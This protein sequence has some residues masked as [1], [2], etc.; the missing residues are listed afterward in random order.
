MISFKHIKL[1]LLLGLAPLAASASISVGTPKAAA[2]VNSNGAAVY[3]LS[4]EIPDG[5]GFHPQIGL[6]YN[7]QS[8]GYGNAGY[9][10]NITGISVITSGGK[11]Q[12]HDNQVKGSTFLANSSFSLDGKRL[13]LES[14]TEG[15]SGAK[16]TIEGDPY[17]SVTIH[18]SFSTSGVGTWFEVIGQDG[19]TYKY[20]NEANSKLEF[21]NPD[22]AN[23]VYCAAW[24]ITEAIDKYGNVIKYKYSYSKDDL[25]I[26]PTCITYGENQIKPRGIKC[27]IDFT[28]DKIPEA[29]RTDFYLL[30]KKGTISK[31]LSTITTSINGN[32]YRKYT[33]G[34]KDDIDKSSKKYTRLTSIV[35]YDEWGNQYNPVT[36]DWNAL[37]A[38]S[39][40]RRV[41][42]VIPESFSSTLYDEKNRSFFAVD[43][44]GDGISDIL[45]QSYMA[46]KAGAQSDNR[47]YVYDSQMDK[48]GNVTFNSSAT[49]YYSLGDISS[50]GAYEVQH[51]G[52]TV[53]DIDG[54]GFNDIVAQYYENSGD[55]KYF[56][57][58][59]VAFG[60][61]IEDKGIIHP[62]TY[63]CH[64][65][66]KDP[67]SQ[68]S[69]NM[70]ING[71]GR[72]EMVFI[73]YKDVI[74]RIRYVYPTQ[75]YHCGVLCVN[76][77][78]KKDDTPHDFYINLDRDPRR[79]YTGD[80]NSDGLQDLLI[81]FEDGHKIYFNNGFSNS[82]SGVFTESNSIYNKDSDLEHYQ[83]VEQGDFNGDGYPDFVCCARAETKLKLFINNR[84][85][86]FEEI[87]TVD[88]P[89]SYKLNEVF[90]IKIVDF[91]NDGKS[92]IVHVGSFI[93]TYVYWYKSTGKNF[94]KYKSYISEGGINDGNWYFTGD[95]NGDGIAELA[96]YGILLNATPNNFIKNKI[97][98]YNTSSQK[99][100][101]GKVS[102]ITD[103][104][105]VKTAFTYSFATN[106]SVYS[107]AVQNEKEYKGTV[108]NYTLP[109]SVVSKKT[110][111]AGTVTKNTTTYSYGNLKIHTSG[112]GMLGFELFTKNDKTL[113]TVEN[114]FVSKWDTEYW[115]PLQTENTVTIGQKQSKTVSD[116]SITAKGKK[117][118]FAYASKETVT[119]FDDNI[120]ET[121]TYYDTNRGVISG[122]K[123][124]N[125]G[126]RTMFKYTSYTYSKKY[127]GTYLPVRMETNQSHSDDNDIHCIVNTYEY[128]DKGNVTKIVNNAESDLKLTEYYQYDEYGHKISEYI[129]GEGV[130]GGKVGKNNIVK[131]YEYDTS[132]RFVID[133]QTV[134]ASTHYTYEYNIYGDLL[135]KTDCTVSTN[136]LVT[137]YTPNGWNEIA[138]IKYPD[139]N[140]VTYSKTWGSDY[141]TGYYVVW[142][143]SSNSPWK[144]TVYDPFGREVLTASVGLKGVDISKETTYNSK[145][146]VGNV[147]NKE[148][149]LILSET[150]TYDARGRK[151]KE[152]SS[153]GA[154]T[155]Y[156]YGKRT[157][158]VT[159]AG[160]STTT[161]YDAWGNTIR[162]TD[163]LGTTVTYTYNSNGQPKCIKTDGSEVTFKYDDAGHRI[164]MNDPDAGITTYSYGADGTLLSQTDARKVT[165]SYSYDKLGR[166][167]QKTYKD[168]S[169]SKSI[170]V[171]EY[172]T[173][174]YG[175]NRIV[176]QTFDGYE[177][178]FTYDK[179]GRVLS[180]T[181]DVNHHLIGKKSY[182]IAY[183]YNALGQKK[184]VSY[185]GTI[186]P[187]VFN[188]SYDKYG[189][190][191][192]IKQGSQSVYSVK[193]YNGLTLETNTVA[194][195]LSKTVDKD[196]Y[197][198]VYQLSGKDSQTFS[199][200]KKTGNLLG[201]FWKHGVTTMLND[202]MRYDKLDRL[203]SVIDKNTNKRTM[204][205]TYANNGNILSKTGVGTYTYDTET[206]PHA[207]T[208]V[209]NSSKTIGSNLVH[210]VFDL[211]GRICSVSTNGANITYM[212]GPDDEKWMTVSWSPN[213]TCEN[214]IEHLYF[215][216]YERIIE[217][218][219]ITEQYF[220][221]NDVIVVSK[222]VGNEDP[223]WYVHQAVTDYL[224]SVLAVYDEY[225]NE[226]FRAKYDAWGK[227]TVY[228][229]TINLQ[230]G[231]TGH[232]MLTYFDLIDMG[233]RL[234]D[235]N[236]GRFISCDN[237]VQAPNNSQSFNRYSY[238]F[239]NPLK[240]TDPDGN[241]ALSTA[242]AIVSI[243]SSMMYAAH[244]HENVWKAGLTTAATY[245]AT[246]A[247]CC[248]GSIFGEVGGIGHELLRS[249]AHGLSS[250]LFLAIEG[251][252]FGSG[253]AAGFVSSLTG[254]Y[255]ISAGWGN[256]LTLAASTTMGG[257]AAWATGGDFLEGA[258]IGFQVGA[259]N[260]AM[261]GEPEKPIKEA[262]DEAK[263]ITSKIGAGAGVT[264]DILAPEVCTRAKYLTFDTKGNILSQ[265]VPKV[266]F[267]LNHEFNCFKE[268]LNTYKWATKIGTGVGIMSIGL[269]AIDMFF[270]SKQT[271]VSHIL[272]IGMAVV[273]FIPPYG[274]IAGLAY[275]AGDT[276]LKTTTNK[277]IG[278]HLDKF[279]EKQWGLTN[280]AIINW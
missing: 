226:V 269:N 28:Y 44:N 43:I 95:F 123:V 62:Q 152:V 45:Q 162:T 230:Y 242:A 63:R 46:G 17:T 257:F 40:S 183:S 97:H 38:M 238:C 157:V 188:Y 34:Y 161:E 31:I 197:P 150:Y 89:R 172:G 167:V 109:I 68:L 147:T 186:A 88:L 247:T 241:I 279:T 200:D 155:T 205:M 111:T 149:N 259:M 75:T 41:D 92:D 171:N 9:G 87:S 148:G 30:R 37:Q 124:F 137:S 178:R 110:T 275:F 115:I 26:L 192:E 71:D 144:K 29:N 231:Y 18:G 25:C 208:S 42:N 85:G 142:E 104:F 190:L 236:L 268:A 239:N 240:Y 76:K 246:Y 253:F 74:P 23:K 209:S 69:V 1:L 194:G 276:I 187:L 84:D 4:V 196:G 14:G 83:T 117:N 164:E 256:N 35:E 243:A 195:V 251:G 132:G 255:G 173:S 6:A 249:G 65:E 56:I 267:G 140:T 22:D 235:P 153:T 237:Y 138:D 184:S 176:K 93:N 224:G 191:N 73:E 91:D 105:N 160:R 273:S 141:G 33:L 156:S 271:K 32:T 80:Y 11:N 103:G 100:S 263:D 131:K 72:D 222:T 36:I 258:M 24:Y 126:S 217:D 61:S 154:S 203:V 248:I 232:E 216:D 165:T 51:N 245:A 182:K 181:R 198:S 79:L 234:Y 133:E 57:T 214:D 39:M 90:S 280:G 10:F 221:G 58:F 20:G 129:E 107:K 59:Q 60:R 12:Y 94:V 128:D 163:P 270:V 219:V 125:D 260:H 227:Q 212:Y 252:D 119:D 233:A 277:S 174:G 204:T 169:N 207:V 78:R 201:R 274:T 218:D 8:D 158:K 166:V 66:L 48:N 77:D 278:D 81:M 96:N 67:T 13:I 177:R 135:K 213:Q 266:T 262:L 206:K 114:S 202:S 112:K 82:Y 116:F 21:K 118:Y 136:L 210:T 250:G 122:Q 99:A 86:S 264:E 16:Y 7:S 130:N 168:K 215:G 52:T 27:Q 108:N 134:P 121:F 225:K 3:N 50:F 189:Y 159:S 229:N 55:E 113:G 151:T 15:C 49:S 265:T 261:H 64:S 143:S 185:P 272:D 145:G 102:A 180:E 53:A 2:D 120:A 5:G 146:Q 98:I 175:T 101:A 70:D 19:T 127:G 223:R 254:S 220:L 106:P 170:Q 193:C 244:N 211:N 139:G 228:T 179:Y 54:D 199:F 47:L